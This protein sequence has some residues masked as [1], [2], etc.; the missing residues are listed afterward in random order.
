[1][2]VT[3]KI[4]LTSEVYEDYVSFLTKDADAI[5]S[6]DKLWLEGNSDNS[7]DW[8]NVINSLK[9]NVVIKQ[10]TNGKL[11]SSQSI[12]I[13]VKGDPKQKLPIVDL[14]RKI[15][16]LNQPEMTHGTDFLI[17][18]FLS[19]RL[20]I[21]LYNVFLEMSFDDTQMEVIDSYDAVNP[22]IIDGLNCR[23]I[24]AQVK[25]MDASLEDYHD[26]LW[27]CKKLQKQ[28][29]KEE[30]IPEPVLKELIE[31]PVYQRMFGV[32]K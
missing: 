30:D 28:Q 20:G 22:V 19:G 8:M 23:P 2:I 29:L 9:L 13:D 7:G 11:S 26:I 4:A 24:K 3:Q 16:I 1:M 5:L 15:N 18:I 25:R 12:R 6:L 32:G 10:L 21:G 17:D 14:N 27:L 31:T